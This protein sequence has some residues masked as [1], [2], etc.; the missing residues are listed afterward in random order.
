MF[1]LTSADSFRRFAAQP[2]QAARPAFRDATEIKAE[3][4]TGGLWYVYHASGAATRTRPYE[5]FLP[6]RESSTV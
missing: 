4:F 3:V 5:E 1:R 2:T 6:R